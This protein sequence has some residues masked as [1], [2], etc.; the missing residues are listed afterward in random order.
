MH[1][2][3]LMAPTSHRPDPR[4][5]RQKTGE[6]EAPDSDVLV[7]PNDDDC[8]EDKARMMRFTRRRPKVSRV[9]GDGVWLEGWRRGYKK[10]G[11]AAYLNGQRVQIN[12]L[13]EDDSGTSTNSNH[14]KWSDC[15]CKK[16]WYVEVLSCG[17]WE[18][19]WWMEDSMCF[20]QE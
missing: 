1:P 3:L 6:T 10:R 2:V 17:E 7:A 15:E 16:R 19:V 8:S 14:G 12:K 9:D 4:T 18:S 13:A 20:G 11:M 5:A